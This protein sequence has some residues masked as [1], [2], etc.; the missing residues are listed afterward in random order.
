M[1]LLIHD[2]KRWISTPQYSYKIYG[3]NIR[4]ILFKVH[5]INSRIQRLTAVLSKVTSSSLNYYSRIALRTKH[6]A[7][8][9]FVTRTWLFYYAESARGSSL[10]SKVSHAYL[11]KTDCRVIMQRFLAE[12][13]ADLF[14]ENKCSKRNQVWMYRLL[15]NNWHF[16]AQ[17]NL[18]ELM[19]TGVNFILYCCLEHITYFLHIRLTNIMSITFNCSC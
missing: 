9:P 2:C 13:N 4:Y 6:G 16:H 10:E 19:H 18:K 17:S 15:A 5:N 12:L 7:C 14:Y 11:R 8:V 1:N 3:Q